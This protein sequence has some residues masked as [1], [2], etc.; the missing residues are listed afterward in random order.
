[1]KGRE[2]NWF[3]EVPGTQEFLR[4]NI[5]LPTNIS[6]MKV[7]LS[8][9]S[10]YKINF[11]VNYTFCHLSFF[12]IVTVISPGNNLQKLFRNSEFAKL[13][14]ENLMGHIYKVGAVIEHSAF[15]FAYVST[16]LHI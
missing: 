4:L 9:T 14:L 7:K 5:F 13:S 12:H 2:L 6:L 3:P 16:D 10:T 15:S 1:M 11:Q 8:G